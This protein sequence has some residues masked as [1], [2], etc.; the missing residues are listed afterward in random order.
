MDFS[1]SKNILRKK[2]CKPLLISCLLI[3]L[4]SCNSVPATYT[5]TKDK[6]DIY[7]DYGDVF[8]PYNIAP[9]NFHIN[10]E[11]SS[12]VTKIYSTNGKS[13]LVRGKD[14]Q[15]NLKDWKALLRNNKGNDLFF[16]VYLKHGKSWS[17]FPLIKNHI[18]AETIDK[19]AVYR[20]IQPLYTKYEDMSINQRDLENFEVTILIDNRIFSTNSNGHCINCHS[21]QNYNST[22]NMQ[23][24]IRGKNGGTVLLFD[25]KQKKVNP[26][27]KGLVSGAVYPSWH[28]TLNY[29]A[30]ST[31]TIGQNFH[32]KN[33]DKVE[34]LDSKSDL[35][36]YNV[37]KNEVTKITDSRDWLETFP[38]WSPDGNYLYYVAAKFK[39]KQ[40][41]IETEIETEMILNYQRIKYNIIRIPF[42]QKTMT[43]G[44]ADTIFN[45][46][47]IGKSA[48]FP[49]VSPDGKYLLFSMADYGNF[50]IW[51][52]NSD[53]FLMDLSTR[54]LKNIDVMNSPDV[55]SYHAWSSSGRWIIFSSRRE[56][57]AYTRLY[58]SYFDKDGKAH[59]PF[60]L[61]QK[62][63]MFYKHY[64]KSFNI[65]EFIVKPAKTNRHKLFKTAS[66]EAEVATLVNR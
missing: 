45:A 57:G 66:G 65:P 17:R 13:I 8:I 15:M 50:H 51:H 23:M 44:K 40:D 30:Y 61:P 3:A 26:K 9:L 59:K 43:F 2:S 31:N 18:T 28:P 36:L 22:G 53:L 4:T 47:S 24:H 55:E 39:P 54:E 6:L 49:R 46:A 34:V 5:D 20:A 41:S 32:S 37:E 64:F 21:F 58:I 62:D 10:N 52:K 25:N 11:A 1:H 63:P 7:P 27:A 38:Y 12:Y 42:N 35:I 16:E 48:T 29:I 56:D 14:V 33:P 19:Y 60:I